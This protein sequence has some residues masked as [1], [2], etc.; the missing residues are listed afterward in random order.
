MANALF[1]PLSGT[2]RVDVLL[3]DGA[4]IAALLEVELALSAVAAEQDAV[5]TDDADGVERAVAA[6]AG[7]DPAALAAESVE[8]GNPV[9][10]L[11]KRL[12]AAAARIQPGA[13]RA[14]HPGATSQD[15]L[16]TALVL[17]TR[18]AGHR[19]TEDL[20]ACADAAA[21]LARDH[22]GTPCAARTLGQQALPTTFGLVAANW[23]AGLDRAR[24]RLAAVLDE[25]PVQYGGAAGTLAATHQHGPAVADALAA[26]LGLAP[27]G[28]PWHTERTR[29]GELAGA[30]GVAA[31]ACAKPAGDV[32]LLSATELAEV[33]EAA[34]GDSSSMPHKRNPAAAV[35]A[36]GAATRAPGLVATLL[37]AQEQEFQRAAGA[38][39]AEWETLTGLLRVAAGAASRLRTCL[40]GLQ[41]HPDAMGRNLALAAGA[42]GSGAGHAAE[43]ADRVLAGRPR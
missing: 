5:S 30:L 3:D 15:V 36:R 19:I 42:Q 13:E 38:W 34:P 10:P 21:A 27:Q 29:I 1:G 35:T 32:V 22:R 31:G 12:K 43:L 17:L 24:V 26:R 39:H 14:V 7:V 8:G 2:D 33:S 16:D 4:W 18:R 41:V 20:A 40:E 11:V 9:I 37:A 23:C 25:L 28:V 6:V